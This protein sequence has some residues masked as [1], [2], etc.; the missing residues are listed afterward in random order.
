MIVEV[1]FK[2]MESSIAI[3]LERHARE[4]EEHLPFKSK[5]RV[6]KEEVYFESPIE[7]KGDLELVNRAFKGEVYYW[8]P[9]KA[10]CIFYGISQPY[11][12]IAWIGTLLD[13]VSRVYEVCDGVSVEVRR[14]EV[15]DEYRGIVD[16][17]ERLGYTTATP[18]DEGSRIVVA[19]KR[20]E[21]GGAGGARRLA[22]LVYP[23]SYGLYIEGEPLFKYHGTARDMGTIEALERRLGEELKPEYARLDIVEE[24][25]IAITA[26]TA[27]QEELERAVVEL[28]RAYLLAIEMLARSP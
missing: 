12:P 25:Y 2:D 27:S 18:L 3:K 28:E 1:Y 10:L 13:P 22:L 8:P 4:I 21:A 17:L 15:S 9:G 20:R 16:A 5:A 6:W 14:H 19:A 11:T 23:E 26:C 7:I 24:C